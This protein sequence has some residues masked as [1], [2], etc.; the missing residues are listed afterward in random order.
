[1]SYPAGTLDLVKVQD[2]IYDWIETVTQGVFQDDEEHISWRDQ[3]QPLLAR[4]MISLKIID[5]PRPVGRNASQFSSM[6]GSNHVSGYG[7]QHEAVLS[8]QVFGNMR[9]HKPMAMQLALDLNSSLVR[10]NI[11]DQLKLAGVAIQEVGKP[12]NLTALEET[13]YEERSG[14]EVTLGLAQNVSEVTSTIGT[15][16]ADVMGNPKQIVLP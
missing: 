8:V 14:F 15:V 2:A 12:R 9:I 3:S 11:L 10:Q 7:I 5:G 1:M 4:P 13:E 16:N 6:Q